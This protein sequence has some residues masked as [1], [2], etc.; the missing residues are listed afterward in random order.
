MKSYRLTLLVLMILTG[1][2]APPSS[3]PTQQVHVRVKVAST[4][5]SALTNV[6]NIKKIE[7]KHLPNLI[8][9]HEKV[10]SGGL[11]EGDEAFAELKDLGIKTVISV[12][13]AIPDRA[14]AEEFGMRYVHL[15]HGYDGVPDERA[16]ELAKAV[17]ELPGPIYLHCHHGKHRSPAAAAVACVGAGMI[18]QTEAR[19]VLQIA[20]TSESYRG[21][22]QSVDEA[23]PIEPALL[24]AMQADFPA[25]A[26]RP[27][28]VDVMV[29]IEHIHDSLKAFEKVGWKTP[30][31][32]SVLSPQRQA[33]LLRESFT[34][35]MR[36]EGTGMKSTSFQQ[37][38]QDAE[39]LCQ[40]LE[41][42]LNSSTPDAEMASKAFAAVT[43]NCKGCHQAFR[44]IPLEEKK[45]RK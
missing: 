23:R 30:A 44:D 10:L 33:L 28:L 25:I 17:Q 38:T 36:T 5:R 42:T 9:V 21:L 7:A 18:N 1:C 45:S 13:G 34:E 37:L 6:P 32:Q 31:G 43:A 16:R 29:S 4:Q 24:T 8:R 3:P 40:S 15:P 19:Q 2:D 27:A 41:D 14:K 22:Y 39:R 12:D 35:L 26:K 11:P 20:G